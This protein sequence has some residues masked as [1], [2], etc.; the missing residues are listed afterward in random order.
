MQTEYDER[1]LDYQ[2]NNYGNYI[3]KLKDDK[4]LQDEVKK[5]TTLLLQ[6]AVFILSNN[7]R[8]MNNFIHA[9][10][11][12][13][14]NDVFYTDTDSLYFENKHWDKLKEKNLVGKNLFQGKDDYGDGGIFYALFFC[15][16]NKIFF[17]YN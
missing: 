17:N 9:I 4:G 13:Y 7:K 14:T 1:I 16:E 6:L 11:G 2:K 12:F 5:F 8:I 3:V 15:A 10:V